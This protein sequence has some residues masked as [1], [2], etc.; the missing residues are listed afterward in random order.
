MTSSFIYTILCSGQAAH[1][2]I[3]AG[4]LYLIQ[5]TLT[6][7]TCH[8]RDIPIIC[9]SLQPCRNHPSQGDRSDS[10]AWTGV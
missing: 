2:A 10:S 1:D 7:R 3:T 8:Q 9:S 6:N 4:V 5:G